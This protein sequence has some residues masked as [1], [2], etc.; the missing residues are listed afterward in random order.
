M[1][2]F[3]QMS[4]EADRW[5]NEMIKQDMDFIKERNAIVEAEGRGR[6]VDY[7]PVVLPGGSVSISIDSLENC[8][9]TM[10]ARAIIYRKGNG[11]LMISKGMEGNFCGSRYSTPSDT[12]C[13]L[14]M[15]LCGTSERYMLSSAPLF[16]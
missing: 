6:K 14:C 10:H 1:G 3:V 12:E 16:G 13:E 9:N 8:I 4:E 5:G 7:V 11:G 2:R 15:E